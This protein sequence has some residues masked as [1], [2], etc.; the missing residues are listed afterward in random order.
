MVVA[1]KLNVGRPLYVEA[2]ANAPS[3]Y[4]LTVNVYHG[5]EVTT[6]SC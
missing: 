4:T 2:R 6:V 3:V 5:R 1:P